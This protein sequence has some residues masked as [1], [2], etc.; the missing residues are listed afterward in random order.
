MIDYNID[1]HHHHYAVWVASRAAGRGMEGFDV[2][3]ARAM[4]EATDLPALSHDKLPNPGE[5]DAHHRK[6]CEAAQKKADER[7]VPM[8]HG[9]TGTLTLA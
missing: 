7:G 1:R 9:G 5:I 8:S 3:L 4:L 2:K 6:W